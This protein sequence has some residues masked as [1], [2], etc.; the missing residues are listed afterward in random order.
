[1]TTKQEVDLQSYEKAPRALSSDLENAL[2]PGG[3]LQDVLAEVKRDRLLRLEIRAG[4]FNVYYGGGNLLRVHGQKNT[5]EMEFDKQ[6][7]PDGSALKALNL[8]P[9]AHGANEVLAW[10]QAF[11]VLVGGMEAWWRTNPRDE[12][13]HCQEMARANSA[14]DGLPAA[15]FC[16]LDLEYQWAQ[17]RFDL[18]AARRRPTT[19]DLTGWM[20][21]SLVFIE[22]KSDERACRGSS[23][24]T[25]HAKDYGSIIEAPPHQ[26][27]GIRREFEGVIEQKRRLGLIHRQWPFRSFAAELP[28]ELLLVFVNL[29]PRCAS[30][31][32]LLSDV[33]AVLDGLVGH[34]DI[35]ALRLKESDFVMRERDVVSWSRLT[36]SA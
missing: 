13:R 3:V 36:R 26:G 34:G 30:V 2:G 31:Q 18:V 27:E 9:V 8:P 10:V 7:F 21:P 16:V 23:G 6:Y 12:R 22:V 28:L 32:P 5:W 33:N 14:M 20:K 24:L 1:M 29:D 15:D 4:R 19:E 35:R 17:R 11:P 25:G